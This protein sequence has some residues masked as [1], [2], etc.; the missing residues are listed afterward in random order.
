A[1]RESPHPEPP[2]P[3]PAGRPGRMGTP[4]PPRARRTATARRLWPP[5]RKLLR[6]ARTSDRRTGPVRRPA[7]SYRGEAAQQVVAQPRSAA[8]RHVAR[9]PARAEPQRL[10]ERG[11]P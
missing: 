7:A 1:G 8:V 11:A 2:G 9:A 6:T 10:L 3:P 4:T 5:R